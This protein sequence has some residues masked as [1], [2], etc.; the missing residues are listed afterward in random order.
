MLS[1]FIIFLVNI[2]LRIDI[3]AILANLLVKHYCT[4]LYNLY[5]QLIIFAILFLLLISHNQWPCSCIYDVCH[6][7]ECIVK[8]KQDVRKFSVSFTQLILAR[9]RILCMISS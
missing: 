1:L 4:L 7:H 5:T 3:N 9:P 6:V 8:N 2:Y